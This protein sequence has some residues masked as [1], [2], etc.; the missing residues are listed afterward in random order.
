MRLGCLS[1]KQ[2]TSSKK[3]LLQFFSLSLTALVVD[4]LRDQSNFYDY[5]PVL[6][7][8]LEAWLFISTGNLQCPWEVPD[9]AVSQALTISLFNPQNC[10]ATHISCAIAMLLSDSTILLCYGGVISQS[11]EEWEECR[12]TEVEVIYLLYKRKAC[13]ILQENS[14]NLFSEPL[15]LHFDFVFRK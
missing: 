10:D 2:L 12:W 6:I 9:S 15:S 1:S 11:L 13:K 14:S 4:F 7:L 3:L 5:L 8:C